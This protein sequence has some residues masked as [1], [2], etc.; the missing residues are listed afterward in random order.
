MTSPTDAPATAP[1]VVG[2]FPA[3]GPLRGRVR[4]PGDKSVSHRGLIAAALATG[5]SRVAGR[6]EGDDV[7]RTEAVLRALGVSVEG[8]RVRG[9]RGLLREPERPLDCGNSGTAI[10]LFAGML[11]PVE[12]LFVL[13]GDES[14]HRRPMGR[15]VEPLRAMGGCVD[16]RAGGTLAPIVVRGSRLRGVDWRLEV[17]SAQAK[18]ALLLA[19]LA[20]EG[21]TVVHVPAVTRRHT[22]EVL[23]LAGARCTVTDEGDGEVARVEPGDLSPFEL[24]VPGDPSQAAFLVVAAA[25]VPGSE[26]VVEDVYLGPG[27]DG[28]LRVLA[29][30]GAAVEVVAR[31]PGRAD[32]RVHHSAL[33]GVEV[34]GG[35]VASLIDEVPVLAIAAAFAEGTTVITGAGELRVKESDRVA[36]MVEGLG[37]LGVRAEALPDGLVVEGG[38][39]RAGTVDA[40][41]DHRVAMAFAVAGLALAEG[42]VRVRGYEAVSTSWP[43]FEETIEGLRCR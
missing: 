26:V 27:R 7:R 20:A 28:F 32:L 19:G 38:H 31:G 23:A 25:L 3:A 10:R 9:G 33:R 14:V 34:G 11:A 2:E 18:S 41:G 21:E 37:R 4:V 16:G 40:H 13:V 5:T 24:V 6:S 29:R 30:M 8:E 22:E 17:P 42:A 39:P 12:G 43:G 1:P 36:T 35:E 15:V